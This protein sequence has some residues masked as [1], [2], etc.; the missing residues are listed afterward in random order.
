MLRLTIYHNI[1]L[2]KDQV[3][4]LHN[5]KNI[6]VVGVSIPIWF[7][8]KLTSEPANEVF[9]NYYLKNP[10]QETPIKILQDGYEISLPYYMGAT[11]T[12]ATA[13]DNLTNLKSIHS[14]S[15][16]EVSSK[17]LLDIID[18]GSEFL[19]YRELDKINVNNKELSIM[20]YVVINRMQKLQ[21]SFC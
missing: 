21:E 19:N 8:G 2:T 15:A 4:D 14:K 1:H 5:G 6:K 18:G 12:V 13:M 11:T 9:C 17:N 10:K 3:Y 7:I 16:K 20:H